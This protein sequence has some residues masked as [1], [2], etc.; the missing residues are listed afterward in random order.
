MGGSGELRLVTLPQFKLKSINW[1]SLL[2]R[3]ISSESSCSTGNYYTSDYFLKR[4]R[5]EKN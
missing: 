2:L 1:R 4:F 3:F 5:I